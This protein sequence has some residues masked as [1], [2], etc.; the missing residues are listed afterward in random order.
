MSQDPTTEHR[1]HCDPGR[2]GCGYYFAF[3]FYEECVLR[4]LKPGEVQDPANKAM[5]CNSCGAK[6]EVGRMDKEEAA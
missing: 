2:G 4:P 1:L 5:W 6:W 3:G